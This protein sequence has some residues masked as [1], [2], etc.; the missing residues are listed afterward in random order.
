[1]KTICTK[2]DAKTYDQL[3]ESSNKSGSTISEKLRSVI[4][5][6]LQLSSS[7]DVK[8]DLPLVPYPKTPDN[9]I[10]DDTVRKIK[11]YVLDDTFDELPVTLDERIEV[12]LDMCKD[13]DEEITRLESQKNKLT[14]INPEEV[15]PKIIEATMKCKSCSNVLETELSKHGYVIMNTETWN[16][17]RKY[18]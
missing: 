13:C 8:Q 18:I 4:Q 16:K 10:S 14:N 12:L 15:I 7:Y 6:S 3:L 11:E 5:D 9:V 2:L 1:M 17:V